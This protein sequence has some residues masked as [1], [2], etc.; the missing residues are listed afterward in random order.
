MKTVQSKAF[1]RSAVLSTRPFELQLLLD[2]IPSC[3][4]SDATHL[5][6]MSMLL[7]LQAVQPDLLMLR[8]LGRALVMW[9]GIQPSQD[10]VNGQMATIFRVGYM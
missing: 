6:Y 9:H 2:R 8:T 10:W 5:S 7:W 4:T 1:V 3:N